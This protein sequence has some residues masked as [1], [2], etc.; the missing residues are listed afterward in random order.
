MRLNCLEHCAL[1]LSGMTKMTSHCRLS[2]CNVASETQELNF[3][4][5]LIIVNFTSIDLYD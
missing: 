5:N 2:T 4:C 1:E 3:K